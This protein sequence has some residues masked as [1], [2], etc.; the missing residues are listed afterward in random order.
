[1]ASIINASNSTGLTLTSDLSGVLQLQQN[2]V[3][4]PALSVAPAFNAYLSSAQAYSTTTYT[5]VTFDTEVFDTN[6]NFASSRFTPTVAGYYQLNATT[7]QYAGSGNMTVEIVQ[8][9]KN[10]VAA[11]GCRV[12]VTTSQMAVNTSTVLYA[13]GS[14]DYFEVFV[15]T[16]AT[17]PSLASGAI[18][19]F[20]SGCLVRGA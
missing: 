20:F 19:T 18:N 6:N 8:I 13:N 17:S 11:C 10:N 5:K 16:S 1:M 14:T 4:L 3:A 12:D 2:G 7:F 15:Y 9:W